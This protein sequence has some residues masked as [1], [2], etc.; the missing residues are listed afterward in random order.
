MLCSEFQL[1]KGSGDTEDYKPLPCNRWSCDY[2][3]P[4]RKRLL[5][6]LAAS[7]HPN[8]LLTITVNA[9]IG[10]SPTHRRELL[11]DAWKRL[12]KQIIRQF[13]LAPD[14][15]WRLT[16]KTRQ[17]TMARRIARAATLT[18]A[19]AITELHYM[20]FLERTKR[21]EPHLHILLRCPFVPQDWIAERMAALASSPVCWIE[22]VKGT[23]AAVRYVTKYVTKAPA[24]FGNAKRYYV[25]RRWRIDPKPEAS[26]F[27]F[28]RSTMHIQRVRWSDELQRRL[29]ARYT[30][31]TLD[32]GWVRFWRPG[33]WEHAYGDITAKRQQGVAEHA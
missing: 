4:R 25:S 10:Q 7:G 3:A 15:R 22:A 31:A 8:K 28:D 21:G 13:A 6:D 26:T 24:Q 5:C 30:W 19:G 20:A 1:V 18:P 29:A 17:P 32:D 16:G 23:N 12:V 33:T 27:V 9:A 11:H 2:C 14:R